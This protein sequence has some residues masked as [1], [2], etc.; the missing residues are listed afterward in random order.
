LNGPQDPQFVDEALEFPAIRASGVHTFD[1]L[2]DGI[3]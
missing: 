1:D 2:F 3:G